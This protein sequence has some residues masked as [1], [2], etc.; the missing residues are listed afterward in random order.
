MGD[1]NQRLFLER[2]LPQAGGP[3]VEI[4]SKEYGSTT[5]FR[6]LYRDVEYVG[7]D[8][9]AGPAVDSVV[10]L[11]QGIGSLAEA[12]FALVIC[13][14]VLEHTPAPWVMAK[15]L[16]RLVRP[17]G[18]LYLSVPWVWRFHPYPDDYFRFSPRGVEA[19][20]PGF[21]WIGAA[22][23][24]SLTDDLVPLDLR[25]DIS[26]IDDGMARYAPTPQGGARKYLPCLMVNMLGRRL[27]ERG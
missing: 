4:G 7:V 12:H 8:L 9:E 10:D 19:L 25:G 5:S 2:H 20:F 6:D 22:Y 1:V 26:M 18:V 24:T 23:S 15:N 17:G 13:C 21:K 27:V 14:S 3:V 11:T 16:T